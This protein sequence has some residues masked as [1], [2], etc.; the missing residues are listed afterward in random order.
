MFLGPRHCL[1]CSHSCQSL[2]PRHCLAHPHYAAAA[3]CTHARLL[4]LSLQTFSHTVK[5][6]AFDPQGNAWVGDDSGRVKV[7]RFAT[8]STSNTNL[9]STGSSSLSLQNLTHTTR[10][11]L[12][13]LA[14]LQQCQQS[15]KDEGREGG[16]AGWMPSF[17]R[18]RGNSA[19]HK[20]GLA[21]E[22]EGKECN[23]GKGGKEGKPPKPEG[24]VRCVRVH[25]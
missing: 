24:P 2:L 10:S 20:G 7:V 13:I 17:C 25:V 12:E 15:G 14:T 11:R 18:S 5:V 21:P 22:E 23:D 16:L 19:V 3:P 6:I 9:S 8:N 1:Y 4:A